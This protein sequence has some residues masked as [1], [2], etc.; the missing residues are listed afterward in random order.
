MDTQDWWLSLLEPSRLAKVLWPCCVTHTW[1]APCL[2]FAIRKAKALGLARHT[3]PIITVSAFSS[4]HCTTYLPFITYH[5]ALYLILLSIYFAFLQ[6]DCTSLAANTGTQKHIT[7]F[8]W[9]QSLKHQTNV[10]L[11]ILTNPEKKGALLTF[12]GNENW[13]LKELIY[14]PWIPKVNQNGS[15]LSWLEQ[16]VSCK[17]RITIFLVTL[18]AYQIGWFGL[19]L[20][21]QDS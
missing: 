4:S 9:W 3:F 8:S 7:D 1:C 18:V 5:F 2:P 20:Q 6:G 21:A 15:L 19:M 10:I 11:I 17:W 12:Y 16:A 14:F 13:H